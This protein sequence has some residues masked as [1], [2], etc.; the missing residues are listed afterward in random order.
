MSMMEGRRAKVAAAVAEYL[1]EGEVVQ[2]AIFAQNKGS[3]AFASLGAGATL[4]MKYYWIVV[5]NERIVVFN[6]SGTGITKVKGIDREV[7]RQTQLGPPTGKGSMTRSLYGT[8]A[9]GE[10]VF[11]PRPYWSEVKAAD[12]ALAAP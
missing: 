6:A 11:V 9:L 5:T 1:N 8:E 10:K 7:A 12:A 2:A 4:A 3:G